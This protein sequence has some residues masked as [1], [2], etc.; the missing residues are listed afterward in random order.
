[1]KKIINISFLIILI[2]CCLHYGCAD[3]DN[4]IGKAMHKDYKIEFESDT[5]YVK[6]SMWGLTGNHI[7]IVF[8]PYS[9]ESKSYDRSLCFTFFEPTIY[10]RKNRD[11]LELYPTIKADIPKGFLPHIIIKQIV[12]NKLDDINRYK[13]KYREYGLEKISVYE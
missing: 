3:G 2:E 8:S 13:L 4:K 5:I 6:A 12:I 7:Q 1:M 9:L 11:T 10:Y